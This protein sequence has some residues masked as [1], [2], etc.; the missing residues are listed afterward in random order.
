[1]EQEETC[2]GFGGVFSVVY[3]EVSRSMMEAKL[4]HIQA[5]GAEYVVAADAGCLMNIS[6]GLRKA[7]S[8]VKP[9]HIIQ[10]LASQ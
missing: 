9:L 4:N 3:P 8:A 5:S 7:N 2:C 6:G 1:L 10:I